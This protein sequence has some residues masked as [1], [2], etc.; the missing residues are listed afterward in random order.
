MTAPAP[1]SSPA[2]ARDP[3]GLVLCGRVLTLDDKSTVA[4]AVAIKGDRVAGVGSRS[5]MARLC[6]R[7]RVVNSGGVI[8][9]GFNDAH[10]HMDTEGLRDHFPSLAGARS[11]GD[12]LSRIAALATRTPAGQWII[13]MPIGEPPFYYG[14]PDVLAEKRMPDRHELDRV[15]PDHPVCILPPSSYWSLIPCHAAVNSRALG[16]LGIDRDSAPRVPGIEILRGENGEPSGIFVERNFPDAMQLD[17]LAKIPRV[18]PADRR[19]AISKAMRA[20]HAH[21]ITSI[22]EGHGCATEILGAYRALHQEGELTMRLGAVVSPTWT[23]LDDASRQMADWM[24]YARGNGLGDAFLR[25]SGIFV[26]YGGEP[27][28]GSLALSDTSNL[29]WSCYVRQANDPKIFEALCLLAAQHDLRL[30]TIVIDKLHEIVPILQRVDAQFPISGK[31]W[32]LEHISIARMDDLAALK[33][34]GVGVTLIPEFHL[35]KAGSRFA[36]LADEACELVAPVVQLASLGVP[37]AAGTDNSPVNPFASMRAM[38]TRRERVTGRILGAAACAS[39][40]LALRCLTVNGA[41]LT[42]EEETKGAARAG[43]LADLA[44]LSGD[45]LATPADALERLSCVATMV[46][47]QFVHGAADMQSAA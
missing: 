10:A 39:A 19:A 14:G 32:V 40:E 15:A 27:V 30:H 16:A 43:N 23:S 12:V 38:M 13:T 42:F 21:G 24:A 28:V 8:V 7:A 25:V 5:E 11:I 46:G 36:K 33:A 1:N 20:Y 34:L 3:R 35:A 6:P 29:G 26:N 9:P 2:D 31:R 41:W 18:A 37:V 44:V 45:P 17:L 22:Y 47:G 4:E